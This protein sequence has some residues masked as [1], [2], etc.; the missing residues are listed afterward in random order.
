MGLECSKSTFYNK[1]QTT[2]FGKFDK[3]MLH[4]FFPAKNENIIIE[5]LIVPSYAS[6]L[7][8]PCVKIL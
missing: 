6:W 5:T 2:H 4:I 3:V 1:I 7:N 8:T